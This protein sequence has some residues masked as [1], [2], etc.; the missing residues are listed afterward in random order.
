[1]AVAEVLEEP[2]PEVVDLVVAVVAQEVAVVEE[3]VAGVQ[4]PTSCSVPTAVIQVQPT[5]YLTVPV[6]RRRSGR[7]PENWLAL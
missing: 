1:M 7:F 2:D 3:E 6:A 5:A 4:L